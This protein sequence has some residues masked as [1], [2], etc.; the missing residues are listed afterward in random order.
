[1]KSDYPMLEALGAE[2]P[3]AVQAEKLRLYGQF[4]GSW[5]VD[6]TFTERKDGTTR[7][8]E[9]EW[10]FG[11]A[12]DGH[13]VQDVWIAPARRLR[14]STR[15]EAWWRYGSTLRWYS[16]S[17]DAWHIAWFDPG[18]SIELRQIGRAVGEE[19]VQMGEEPDGLLTRWRFFEIEPRSFHWLGEIS[20]DRG[21]HWSPVTEMRATRTA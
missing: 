9:G 12:L 4:V 20:P 21:Q 19:I 6:I 11:W 7:E 17:I 14:Q 15:P 18:R 8:T 3:A 1:M 10:H 2:G 13:T 5:R 16:P